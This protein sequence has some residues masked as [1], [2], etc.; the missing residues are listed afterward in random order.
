[1]A[2]ISLSSL[3]LTNVP[4]LPTSEPEMTLFSSFPPEVRNMIWTE[5]ALIP[6]EIEIRIVRVIKKAK[7]D[8]TKQIKINGDLVVAEFDYHYRAYQIRNDTGLLLA[9]R[10]SHVIFCEHKN[11]PDAF[12][13]WRT[14]KA[15]RFDGNRDKIFI[16]N[17]SQFY[18][19]Q[20]RQR[21]R[22]PTSFIYGLEFIRKLVLNKRG[23]QTKEELKQ[24]IVAGY[25]AR[26]NEIA[27][28]ER[29]KGRLTSDLNEPFW[30]EYFFEL[31]RLTREA[32]IAS[33][34]LKKFRNQAM[35]KAEIEIMDKE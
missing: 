29:A 24:E 30:S 11:L 13:L 34:F 25:K 14:G 7:P 33:R 17:I 18:L 1:M 27:A 23:H 9:C 5:A 6:A 10:E 35:S 31:G 20:C 21:L 16:S 32:A 26:I 22:P 8:S 4:V 3:S 28:E 12:C 2:S 19:N 15:I